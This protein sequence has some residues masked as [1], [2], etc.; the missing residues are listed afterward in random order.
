M[1][2]KIMVI[3]M[4]FVLCSGD[5][6]QTT[7]IEFMSDVFLC[8]EVHALGCTSANLDHIRITAPWS[9]AWD[10]YNVTYAHV[11][12]HE[13]GHIQGMNETEAEEYAQ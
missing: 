11:L 8:A 7:P 12:R 10:R 1:H 3:I 6:E 5:I 4:L 13:Q 9:S 2:K